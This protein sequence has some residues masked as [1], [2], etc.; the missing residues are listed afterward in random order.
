MTQPS[1]SLSPINS[2]ILI[3]ASHEM[4]DSAHELLYNRVTALFEAANGSAAIEFTDN[5]QNYNLQR[6]IHQQKQK[7]GRIDCLMINFHGIKD[8]LTFNK[9]LIYDASAVQPEDFIELEQD[10]S[11]IL[12]SCWVGCG[13]LPQ[14]IADISKKRVLAPMDPIYIHKTEFLWCVQHHQ[15]EIFASSPSDTDID[16][17]IVRIFQRNQTP[18][19]CSVPNY[20]DPEVAVFLTHSFKECIKR[21]YFRAYTRGYLEALITL[22]E[23]YFYTFH[24]IDEAEHLYA[25]AV[26]AGNHSV[27]A[28]ERLITIGYFPE[29]LDT[30]IEALGAANAIQT[31]QIAARFESENRLILSRRWYSKALLQGDAEALVAIKRV[32][33]K[34]RNQSL[35]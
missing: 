27:L 8:G 18:I 30:I 1:I 29:E 9:S 32:I 3:V 33:E 23:R 2:R 21:F 26:R 16:Q 28:K 24:D 17:N 5:L 25:W 14:K 22:A 13:A 10:A 11:I 12:L 31:K 6:I 7:L 19:E 4:K 20:N 35:R 15:W 34:M